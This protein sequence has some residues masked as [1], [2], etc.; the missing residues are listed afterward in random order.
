MAEQ[1]PPL[2]KLRQDL[3]F[4]YRHYGQQACYLLIDPINETYYQVGITEY[5]FIKQLDGKKTVSTILENNDHFSAEQIKQI[6]QWLLQ[7][8]LAYVETETGWQ[9]FKPKKALTQQLAHAFNFLFI[10]IPLGSPD[11][12]ITRLYPFFRWMLNWT[13]FSLWLLLLITGF[14]QVFAQSDRFWQSANQLLTIHNTIYLV[15]AWVIIKIF[16]ELFHGLVCK[17]YGGYIHQAGIL[18]ILFV[19]IGG[20]VNATASWKFSSKWQRM[21][22]AVA[23]IYIELLIA[24]I[25]AWTWAYS[26]IGVLN[27]LAYNIII[28]AS[29]GTF[30]F[31]MNPLM[32]FDGYYILV[33]LVNI[34]NLYTSGQRYIHYLN[35]CYLQGRKVTLPAWSHPN[36]IK[37]YGLTALFWRWLIIMSLLIAATTL[38][39]GAG[40]V[41]VVISIITLLVLPLVQF[42]INLSQHPEGKR[43]M[44]RLIII[45]SLVIGLSILFLTQ[46]TYAP[47]LSAPAIFDYQNAQTIRADSA[48]FV[49][50]ILV[51][52]NDTVEK[53]QV[54]IKL[55]NQELLAEKQDLTLQVEL[56]HLKRQQYFKQGL[57]GDYQAES[58]KIKELQTKLLEK[59][60]Q[61]ENLTIHAPQSG[62]IIAQ[63][64]SLLQDVYI[65]RGEVLLTLVDPKQLEIKISIP[66]QDIDVFRA[67]EGK[68]VMVYRDGQPFEA[69]P[70]TLVKIN[71]SASQK[72]FY[73]ALTALAGAYLPIKPKSDKQHTD[74]LEH[75]HLTPRFLG[76]VHMTNYAIVRAGETA[77]VV[78]ESPTQTLWQLFYIKIKRFIDN[79]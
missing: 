79:K 40:I 26:E 2:I 6:V 27:Y 55:D 35:Q 76:V 74:E 54:L 64:L 24:S 30:F 77:K 31:N 63:N 50:H 3:T 58:E 36:F 48:G 43:I 4:T 52:E 42:F 20:Y 12:L 5:H 56:Y 9:L 14:Y 18:L 65:Q 67:N 1:P 53:G 10:R 28:I 46:I 69:L 16:H 22:V 15:S 8:Q 44:S 38:F 72:I 70:A 34:P 60:K 17:K 33:D 19:P 61:V 39:Y 21:H 41:L 11:Y 49:K 47:H 29:I 73:P 71:P 57:M 62:K 75:E 7:N 66:Q 45:I 68:N 13:F 25:A 37:I 59:T 23:G 51:K 78:I 32:R